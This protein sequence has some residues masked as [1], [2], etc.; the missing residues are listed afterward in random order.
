MHCNFLMYKSHNIMSLLRDMKLMSRDKNADLTGVFYHVARHYL[1]VCD[2]IFSVYDKF[3]ACDVTRLFIAFEIHSWDWRSIK[4]AC[5]GY[6]IIKI[7]ASANI[8]MYTL[9]LLRISPCMPL[10]RN[11]KIKPKFNFS[12]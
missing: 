3:L 8:Y 6:I 7:N 1:N 10:Q 5:S 4:Q 2:I 12:I 11:V 9:F